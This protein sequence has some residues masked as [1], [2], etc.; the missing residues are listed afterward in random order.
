M[1]DLAVE[2]EAADATLTFSYPD[3]LLTGQPLTDLQ[4]VEIYR[5]VNPSPLLTVPR[6][7][8]PSRTSAT[9]TAPAGG[10][11]RA[12]SN[13]RQAEEAFY[14]E[15]ERVALL[16]LFALGQHT[17]GATI[18]YR[19]PLGPLLAKGQSPSSL[20]YAVVSVRRNGERSPLSNIALLSPDVPPGPPAILTVT[21]EEGRICLEWLAPEKDLLRRPAKV[22]GYFVYRRFLS[23]EDYRDPLNPAPLP[24]TCYVDTAASYGST[25][26]YTIRATLLDKPKVE[27]APAVEA[28][29]DYRDVFPPPA[30]SRLEA[31][32]EGVLVRLVWD[33]V[34]ASD[35][36]GYLVFRGEG[37]AQAA[38][39]NKDPIQGS[40]F[41]DASVVPRRRYR[42]SVRAVD[43]AGNVSPPSPEA[44][45]EP[46]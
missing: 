42:Y 33:P 8:A 14:R 43:K 35:L 9:D 12:A 30:P 13:V 44:V 16:P 4:S 6:P 17:L 29:I 38:R 36:A 34:A 23:D 41:T 27:G 24:G 25:L 11:R 46:F 31:L 45:A 3:R 2:Q 1:S 37:Q 26:V 21:P 32:S 10:A 39:L 18:V 15:A 40:F 22:G 19:D 7:V 20:A 5:A 28:G